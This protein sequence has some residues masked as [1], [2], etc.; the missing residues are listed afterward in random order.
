[1][2]SI[3]RSVKVSIKL[4]ANIF[5]A[6]CLSILLYGSESWILNE[7]LKQSLNSFATSAYRIMLN[8]K[9]LD[10]RT[11]AEIY[12]LTG[13]KPLVNVVQNLQLRYIG[14]CL[15]RK[16]AEPIN[17]YALYTPSESHGKRK[18]GQPTKSYAKYILDLISHP[19][20]TES[21]LREFAQ[22]RKEWSK[23]VFVCTGIR[24][25]D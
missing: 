24:A 1:M 3:W 17:M 8:I 13:Q 16:V 18:Q 7:R 11:N 25:P 2:N 20:P 5:R 4:K 19:P 6:I 22:D 12:E 21:K 14:H 9:R 15:R 23:R 10:K